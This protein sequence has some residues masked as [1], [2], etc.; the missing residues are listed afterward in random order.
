MDYAIRRMARADVGAVAETFARMNKTREQYERY[1]EEN[2][3]GRRV[4]LVAVAGGEVVGYT[5][6]LW[7]PGYEPFRAEGVPEINDLNVTEEWRRRGVATA[8]IR[9]AERIAREAGR[10]VMGI[11][12]GLT[13]DYAAA[14]R[15]YP[16]LGYAEDGR[17]VH[18]TPYGDVLYLTRVL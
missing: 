11:G 13:P 4:T 14:R 16:K 1:F 15:L 18:H 8:L 6:L 12:V 3:L 5:N 10:P 9:E 7:E 2:R 17:G